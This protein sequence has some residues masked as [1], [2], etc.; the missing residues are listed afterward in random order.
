MDPLTVRLGI[1]YYN[2]MRGL[3]LLQDASPLS[4]CLLPNVPCVLSVFKPCAVTFLELDLDHVFGA[5]GRSSL[6]G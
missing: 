6:T 1:D 3:P 4:L 2:G 5:Y